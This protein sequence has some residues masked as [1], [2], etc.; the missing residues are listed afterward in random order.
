MQRIHLVK[1]QQ[2]SLLLIQVTNQNRCFKASLIH[3]PDKRT[4]ES[5]KWPLPPMKPSLTS[6]L[7][8]ATSASA[9]KWE[10]FVVID[11]IAEMSQPW[12][13]GA[14]TMSWRCPWKLGEGSTFPLLRVLTSKG[15]C[16]HDWSIMYVKESL[17]SGPPKVISWFMDTLI[18]KV[19]QIWGMVM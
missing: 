12:T 4:P 8:P 16:P 13:Q 7:V 14:T 6:S 9:L 18:S 3:F 10:E 19:S 11:S 2:N 5:L 1:L 15:L 17:G